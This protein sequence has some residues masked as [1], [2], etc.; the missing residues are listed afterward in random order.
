MNSVYINNS[1]MKRKTTI[2]AALALLATAGT[3]AHAEVVYSD[4]T[5]RF[6]LVDEAKIGRAHV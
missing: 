2:L 3:K 4:Q 1:P 5:V 6:T